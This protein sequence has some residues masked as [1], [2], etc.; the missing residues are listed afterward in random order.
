MMIVYVIMRRD[1]SDDDLTSED[2]AVYAN[3]IGH[4]AWGRL[5]ELTKT[6]AEYEFY[7]MITVELS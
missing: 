7:Y 3:S 5:T 1:M 4:M 2:D 6:E